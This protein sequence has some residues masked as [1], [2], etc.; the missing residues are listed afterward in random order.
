MRGI[1]EFV[2]VNSG[3]NTCLMIL[4]AVLYDASIL[5]LET[6]TTLVTSVFSLVIDAASILSM[7]PVDAKIS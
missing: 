3:G 7:A 5:D 4:Q 1:M 6:S 2:K